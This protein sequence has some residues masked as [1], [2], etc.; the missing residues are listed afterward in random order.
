MYLEEHKDKI[1]EITAAILSAGTDLMESP[2]KDEDVSRS[3]TKAYSES[4]LWLQWMMFGKNPDAM[5]HD[6]ELSSED[7][8]AVCG[9]VWGQNGVA[10]RCR[11]CESDP[12][13]V[14]C[15]PCFQ[16]GNHKDHDYSILETGGGCC[17]CG[18]ATSHFAR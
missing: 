6:M 4:L 16:N 3:S 7:D 2:K 12:T 13:C 9:T 11:T 15:V 8:R 17:D 10:Y 5:L 18:D 14:I 1:P